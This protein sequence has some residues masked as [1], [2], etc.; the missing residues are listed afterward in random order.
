MNDYI[1]LMHKSTYKVIVV[2]EHTDLLFHQGYRFVRYLPVSQVDI[3]ELYAQQH[4]ESIEFLQHNM[5]SI[6]SNHDEMYN[7]HDGESYYYQPIP[8]Y[9]VLTTE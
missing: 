6:K 7:T 4:E 8:I 1:Q 9:W 3:P 5:V 2:E